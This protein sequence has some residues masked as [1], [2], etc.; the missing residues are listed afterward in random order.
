MA[1][2]VGNK[3]AH[4][5]H[6][7]PPPIDTGFF[8]K[9]LGN[10]DWGM[11]NRLSRIF[12]PTSGNTVMLAFDH[13]YIMGATAGLERL[14]VTIAPLCGH[15]D[16]LMGTRGFSFLWPMCMSAF[17]FTGSMEFV[18]VNLLVSAFNPFVTF[19]LAVMLGT[20]HLFYGISMLGRF[21]NMGAKKPYLIFSLCDE[22]FAIDNGT[23]I[24][25]DVDRGWFYFF[26]GLLNQSSWVAGATLGG[27]LGE[28]ITFNTSGLDFIM[29]AMFAVIFVDQWL[30]TKRK[31][32]MAALTG[33]A[34]PAICLGVFGADNF[35]IP[36]LVAMLVMFILL[37]PYLDDLKIDKTDGENETNNADKETNA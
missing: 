26:V 8:A 13:G 14:D 27:L 30:T 6:L 20:R 22:T 16:V 3:A 32:H 36:S 5:Y 17:I 35:M 12:S 10:T 34:V 19:M 1:D 23:I 18:T 21:K 33:I 28:R 31:S 37:R 9:G 11:K 2:A 25:A 7:D 15:A 29:T 24:A 4:D